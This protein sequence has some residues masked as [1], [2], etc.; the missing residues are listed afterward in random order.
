MPAI[1]MCVFFWFM[2][3]FRPG[4]A[5]DRRPV[6]GSPDAAAA[7]SDSVL[8]VEEGERPDRIPGAALHSTL[9]TTMLCSGDPGLAGLLGHVSTTKHVRH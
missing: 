5:V 1:D 7:G 3:L 9:S 6:C 4:V 2:W 8:S